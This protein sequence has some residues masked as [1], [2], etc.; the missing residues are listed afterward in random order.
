MDKKEKKKEK[1]F[2]KQ[3]PSDKNVKKENVQSTDNVEVLEEEHYKKEQT[4]STFDEDKY[5]Q[6]ITK[7]TDE[8]KKLV[9]KVQLAQAELINYRRRKDEE[10]SSM[11]KYANVD[12]VTEI[13]NVVDNFERAVNHAEK[14]TNDEVKKYNEGI[15]LIYTNLKSIL[16]KFGV[17]EINNVGSIFN[18]NEEQA[19]L[20]DCVEDKDDEVVLEVLQ[21]GY[22]LKDRVIRP[23]SVKI[24]QK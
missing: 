8:N 14:S 22:K 12:L 11:L 23:A 21:K 4:E 6:E 9:E 3:I 17:E 1:L 7:L 24:N 2:K 13:L 16:Q 20:T 18:P 15:N 10:V 19:L 5:K